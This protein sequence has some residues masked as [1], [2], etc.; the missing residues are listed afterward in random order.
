MTVLEVI[1][2]GAKYLTE[3]GV[4]SPR[5]QAESLLAHVLRLP[6]LNLYLRFDREVAAADLGRVRELVQ[7]RGRREPLQHLVGTVSFCGL[8]LHVSPNALIPRPETELLA[9]AGWLFLGRQAASPRSQPGP[10]AVDLGTGSGCLAVTLALKCPTATLHALDL[11]PAALELA[12]ANAA[13]H[14]VA[15]RIHFRQSDVFAAL[16]P[17]V[18]AELILSNPPYIPT[19]EIDALEPEVRDHDPR[20]ALD[21]GPDGLG[22]LRALAAGAAGFLAPG[23]RLMVEIGDG[24]APAVGALLEARGWHIDRV[25]PDYN[26]HPRIV[27]AHRPES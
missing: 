4:E 1:Q 21:G 23:G 26:G 16:P 3:K 5:L 10:V 6:R 8:E 25:E 2:R 7:R 12:R 15:D 9:E 20:L 14:G 13:A 24:Q 18:R 11:S 27:I 22:V 19:A 17:D